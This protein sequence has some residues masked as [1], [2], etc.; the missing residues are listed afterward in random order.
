[1]GGAASRGRRQTTTRCRI[2]AFLP[3]EPSARE[4]H[5][6]SGGVSVHANSLAIGYLLRRQFWGRGCASEIG[7][8]GLNCAFD[9]LGVEAVVSCTVRHYAR[10]EP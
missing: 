2:Y 3:P 8:A 5:G 9:G 4:V 10:L 1:L 6:G 7:R